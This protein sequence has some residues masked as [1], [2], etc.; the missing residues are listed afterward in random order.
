[1]YLLSVV[2][3][4]FVAMVVTGAAALQSGAFRHPLIALGLGAGAAIA[5][6]TVSG[7]TVALLPRQPER[8]TEHGAS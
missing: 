6:K 8:E 2:L 1:M 7:Y 4:C 5:L 3:H